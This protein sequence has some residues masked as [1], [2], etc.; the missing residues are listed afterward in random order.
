MSPI[1]ISA[2]PDPCP[3]L[4]A[5]PPG[6]LTVMPSSLSPASL[7]RP[8]P[9]PV[10]LSH[11]ARPPLLPSSAPLPPT[12]LSILLLHSDCS[13]FCVP[14]QAS[15]SLSSLPVS[16]YSPRYSPSPHRP[17]GFLAQDPSAAL[18]HPGPAHRNSTLLS[19]AHPGITSCSRSTS[20]SSPLRR[21]SLS[22]FWAKI[23]SLELRVSSTSRHSSFIWA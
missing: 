4:A 13:L 9:P 19:P 15:S 3:F 5:R 23:S 2:A 21:F 10:Y 18:E 1:S 22:R 14:A 8:V 20:A 6:S 16:I 17:R 7:F 11:R 12:A